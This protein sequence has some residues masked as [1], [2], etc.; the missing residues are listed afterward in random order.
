MRDQNYGGDVCGGGGDVNGNVS[1]DQVIQREIHLEIKA[2]RDS[3]YL[4]FSLIGLG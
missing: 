1:G 2:H 3:V 4:N